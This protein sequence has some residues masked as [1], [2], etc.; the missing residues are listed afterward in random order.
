M[1]VA[2]L[3]TG[4]V[5]K[6][7][8]RGFM[9]LGHEVMM[10]SRDRGNEKLQ[11][12][13]KEGGARATGGTFEEAAKFGE[14]IV[15]ATLGQATEAA[16]AAAGAENLRGKILIDTTNPLDMASMP[17]K[18]IGGVGDSG[19]ERVQRQVPEAKVV[20]AFNTVGNAH[21]FKPTF[22]A[23][24]TMFVCGDDDGAKKQVAELLRDFGWETAD[25]GGINASHYL[26]AMCL[27]WVMY[28]VKNGGW[29]HAFKLLKK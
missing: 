18:L 21:M 26:E 29:N 25:V 20:K 27:V 15:L 10:G 17:P 28:A 13:V 16:L 8:G 3:G 24:P 22:S 12:W 2:I 23:M 7:I 6:A 14:L 5:G 9:A 4:D 11:A 19:G 1:K